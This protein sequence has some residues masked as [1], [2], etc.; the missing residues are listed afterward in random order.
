MAT[1]MTI[2]H[3]TKPIEDYLT[4]FAGR[5]DMEGYDDSKPIHLFEGQRDFVWPLDMW[6]AF[7][8][9]ILTGYP[10][11]LMVICN[12][13]LMD[14]GNRSTV[15][16][17]WKRNEFRV[18]IGDWT[19]N[20][21]EMMMNPLLSARWNRC[22]IP[23]T[24]VMNATADEQSSMF[25]KY[26]TSINLTT[27]HLLFNRIHSPLVSM[28][29]A[30]IG[31]TDRIE[32]PF[33]DLIR[34]VWKRSWRKT[35]NRNELTLAFQI[36]VASMAGPAHYHT[37]F[38]LHLRRIMNTGIGDI[39]LS[40]LRFIC[41]VVQSADPENKIAAKV[42]EMRFKEYVGP[43]IHDIHSMTRDT[44]REKWQTFFEQAYNVLTKERL[45]KLLDVGVA[46]ANN[47]ARI[48]QIA[49]NVSDLLAGRFT[50]DDTGDETHEGDESDESN[51]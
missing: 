51:V 17:K 19:G 39:D 42:K 15:L 38:Q 29:A 30:M 32:F 23:M 45:K 12:N 7:I 24:V 41:E 16:M 37:K 14:G 20:Y 10:I 33:P 47:Q 4:D 36:I 35:K 49:T 22:S 46:R 26:N 8:V 50:D 11:P 6:C 5:S 25:E 48:A 2:E 44:F 13:E 21:D 1:R 3:K 34:S 43:M 40:N 18:T 28:A 31:Q 9:S 27:G